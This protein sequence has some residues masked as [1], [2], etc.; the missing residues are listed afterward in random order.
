MQIRIRDYGGGISPAVE[1]RMYD[2]SYSTVSE[3]AKDTGAEAYMIPGEDVNNV[4]GMGFGLPMCKA[5]I[6]MFDGGLDVQS[7]LG[8]GTDVYIKLKGPS[9]EMLES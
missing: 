8:W 1:E 2:Y 6:D 9:K 7:L 3:K 5:Y 4:S